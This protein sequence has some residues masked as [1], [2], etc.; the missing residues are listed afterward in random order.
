MLQTLLWAAVSL[1][2]VATIAM[3]ACIMVGFSRSANTITDL[4]HDAGVDPT[5]RRPDRL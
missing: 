1:T 3:A 2:L 4:T 5:S